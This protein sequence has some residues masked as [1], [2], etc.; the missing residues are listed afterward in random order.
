MKTSKSVCLSVLLFAAVSASVY[1]YDYLMSDRLTSWSIPWTAATTRIGSLNGGDWND[2]YH[3]MALGANYEFYF[4]GKKVTHIRIWTNGY[5]TFGFEHAPSDTNDQFNDTIPNTANPNSYA[6]PWWDDWDLHLSGDI[7]Y[8]QW[9]I[10]GYYFTKIEWRAVRHWYFQEGPVTF[11]VTFFSHTHTNLPDVILFQYNDVVTGHPSY[12]YG[13]S[14]TVGI[15][16]PVGSQGRKYSYNEAKLSTDDE[17]YFV[18][19]VPVY[20]GT[21]DIWDTHGKPAI[22]LFR[23]DDGNWFYREADATLHGPFQWGQR[24]DVP[25]PGDYDGDGDSDECVLRPDTYTWFGS[26]P[27]FAIQFGDN[28]DIPVPAD[29]DGNGTID[30]AVFRPNPGTWFIFK[31]D[32]GTSEV[33]QWGMQ[34][35]IPLP[36]D[37]DNDG[38]AD[39]AVFRPS[40]NTWFIRKSSYP[41]SPWIMTFGKDGDVPMP[42]NIQTS[43]YATLSVFRP[44]D[45][46]WYTYDQSTGIWGAPFNWGQDGDNAAPGDENG[47]GATDAAVFRPQNGIWFIRNALSFPTVVS[48]GTIGD[49][50][51]FRRNFLNWKPAT[52]NPDH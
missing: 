44:S 40:T 17:I 20:G 22:T 12:D 21:E 7:Y 14:G 42:T 49:I 2:G 27:T 10:A 51:M 41:A 25:L 43:S 19:F 50:P 52:G 4:Y 32:L 38:K 23:P 26:L 6:A 15:E 1:A 36:A 5:V 47:G 29:Y 13:K 28:G 11:Q 9:N 35:D 45:G 18:P 39:C 8:T 31:R 37:S 34:G 30:L 16:H 24:G 48:Y 33:Y 46:N 3:D